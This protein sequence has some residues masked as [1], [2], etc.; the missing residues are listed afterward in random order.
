MRPLPQPHRGFFIPGTVMDK[1][2]EPVTVK[3]HTEQLRQLRG[4]AEADG[5]GVSEYIRHLIDKDLEGRRA[6]FNALT[7]I[8]GA[9]APTDKG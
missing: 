8:F 4:V 2:T 7:S 3:L 6:Q 5:M 9:D 1:M